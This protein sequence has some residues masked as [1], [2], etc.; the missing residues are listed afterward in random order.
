MRTDVQIL[1]CAICVVAVAAIEPLWASD[2]SGV[3]RQVTVPVTGFESLTPGA[4]S[5]RGGERG[6]RGAIGLSQKQAHGGKGSLRLSYDF[7]KFSSPLPSRVYAEYRYKGQPLPGKV[8]AIRVWVRGDGQGRRLGF[9]LID[10]NGRTWQGRLGTIDWNGWREC[11]ATVSGKLFHF[12][13]AKGTAATI[14]HPLH[15]HSFLI[16][17]GNESSTGTGAIEVDDLAVDTLADPVELM[18]VTVGEPDHLFVGADPK[19]TVQVRTLLPQKQ[20]AVLQWELSQLGERVVAK[21]RDELTLGGE[22]SRA[23]PLGVRLP[24]RGYYQLAVSLRPTADQTGPTQRMSITLGRVPSFPPGPHPDSPFAVNGHS[25]HGAWATLHKLGVAMSRGDILWKAVEPKPGVWDFARWDR[26]SDA[27]AEAGVELLAILDYNPPWLNVPEGKGTVAEKWLERV[28]KTVAHYHKR[29]HTWDIWN[30]PNL[31]WHGSKEELAELGVRA[32]RIIKEIDPKATVIYPSVSGTSVMGWL[33]PLDGKFPF[34]ALSVHPYCRPEPP[35]SIHLRQQMLDLRQWMK[36]HGENKPVWIGEVGWPTSTDKL[37][38]SETQQAAYLAR[39][40][41]LGLSAQVQKIV[42]YQPFSGRERGHHERQYGFL[43]N[44]HSPKPAALAFAQV[45]YR[46]THA[47]FDR[48]IDLGAPVRCYGFATPEHYV[49]VV[50]SVK[51]KGWLNTT[52]PKAMKVE[53]YDGTPISLEGTRLA[54]GPL[55]HYVMIPNDAAADLTRALGEARVEGIETPAVTVRGT[56]VQGAYLLELRNQRNHELDVTVRAQFPA[57]WRSD[58]SQSQTVPLAASRTKVLRLPV[59]VPQTA[60]RGEVRIGLDTGKWSSSASQACQVEHVA[61][62]GDVKV[63]GDLSEWRDVGGR[64]MDQSRDV[65]PV[66][67]QHIWRGPGD[68]SAA[69][70]FGWNLSGLFVAAR[71]RDDVQYNKANGPRIWSGDS[72]QVGV[73]VSQGLAPSRYGERSAE[74]GVALTSVGVQCHAWHGQGTAPS[75]ACR[76]A[77]V[78]N[79]AKN[80]TYYELAIPWSVLGLGKPPG[81]GRVIAIT[82]V[83]NDRD[84]GGGRKWLETSPGLTQQKDPALFARGLLEAPAAG[85]R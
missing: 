81:A 8:Q 51:R 37:G 28:R 46:L 53:A 45:A 48:V 14:A 66:D 63:D 34:D 5:A 78:R 80:E 61:Y 24:H 60:S 55:P 41:V 43:H 82:A 42:Y 3:S 1:L 2:P 73:E 23:V 84:A 17:R 76:G 27:A 10:A 20:I 58:V 33:K 4:W 9:R 54:I 59:Q 75:H 36:A 15:F 77:A 13:G 65:G 6:G 44:D 72:L 85:K 31:T 40:F 38:V 25:G 39:L 64:C 30:E 57:G 21:G 49:A 22:S 32:C 19:V 26:I 35:E 47:R 50:W 29:I 79:A 16:D 67:M 52:W 68:L 62:M 11:E 12:G 56:L 69:I 18:G 70:N 83:I 74:V 7:S 71:V